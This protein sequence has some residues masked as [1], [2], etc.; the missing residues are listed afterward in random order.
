MGKRDQRAAVEIDHAELPG[1]VTVS[2]RAL[3]AEAGVVDEVVDRQPG[4]GDVG[5]Q[6]SRRGRVREVGGEEVNG[7]AVLRPELGGER[8]QPVGPARGEDQGFAPGGERA[9]E[10]FAQARRR[11]GDEGGHRFS[12]L[13]QP[14]RAKP[15]SNGSAGAARRPSWSDAL[16]RAARSRP[17]LRPARTAPPPPCRRRCT[18]SPPPSARRAAALPAAPPRSGGCRSCRRDGRRRW[19]RR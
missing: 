19:R 8:L 6:P 9:G 3:D 5:Q 1:G 13:D 4:G 7:N 17:R 14:T 15:P 12:P 2:E 10:A 16:A 11:A 18:C